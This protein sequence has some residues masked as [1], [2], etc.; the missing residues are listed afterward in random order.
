MAPGD[1]R[2]N[3]FERLWAET[4][5]E[6]LAAVRAV[7]ESGW[8]VLGPE[9]R[10]LEAGLAPVLGRG[11]VVGCGSGLDAL[12]IALRAAGL[13]PG[14]K[15]VTTPLSA[16]ATTLAIVRAGGIPV[17]VDVDEHGLV[18]LD[19]GGAVLASDE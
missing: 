17:F 14:A 7:G 16:F 8:Y 18:D 12:E 3:G 19:R 13:P 15:V 10:G 5:P 11:Q 1:V 9:V 4:G 6:V 2:L